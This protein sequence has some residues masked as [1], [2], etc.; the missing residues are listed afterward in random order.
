[1]QTKEMKKYFKYFGGLF[2]IRTLIAAWYQTLEKKTW[3]HDHEQDLDAKPNTCS[4]IGGT[5]ENLPDFLTKTTARS[6]SEYCSSTT[7]IVSLF[8]LLVVGLWT[9]GHDSKLVTVIFHLHA[10]A[11]IATCC[12]LV[13]MNNLWMTEHIKW[14]WYFG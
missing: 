8:R 4:L 5:N 9:T 7:G 6:V 13:L 2:E 10:Y 3:C 14:I 12:L 11:C 1:M